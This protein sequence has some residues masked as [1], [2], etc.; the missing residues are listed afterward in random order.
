MNKRL[1]NTEVTVL[2]KDNFMGSRIDGSICSC[3]WICEELKNWLTLADWSL[4]APLTDMVILIPAWISYY[5]H[6]KVCDENIYPFISSH[7][8][9]GMRLLI[10]SGLKVGPP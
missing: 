4:G 5:I 3:A 6:Y 2:G 7:I 9:L 1:K 8:L 10:H